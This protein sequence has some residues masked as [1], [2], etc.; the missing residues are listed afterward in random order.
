MASSQ[1]LAGIPAA[2][3]ADGGTGAYSTDAA[4]KQDVDLARRLLNDPRWPITA[5]LRARVVEWLETIM[6]ATDDDRARVNAIKGLL[7][8]DK[9]NLES[10]KVELAAE[11]L[12]KPQEVNVNHAGTVS[13]E[14]AIFARLDS[15]AD[16]FTRSA[17]RTGPGLVPSDDPRKPV[18]PG[19]DQ[20]R[21]LPKAG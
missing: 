3:F 1:T 13:V 7:T 6:E 10:A 4:L 12:S 14:H 8:A 9:L 5:R 18:D 17:S 16:A 11:K 21:H 2:P 15:L 20:G 19:A